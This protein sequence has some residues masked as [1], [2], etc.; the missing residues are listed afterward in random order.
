LLNLNFPMTLSEPSLHTDALDLM[1]LAGVPGLSLALV[2]NDEVNQVLALGVRNVQ[3]REPVNAETI[4]EAASLSK[5]VVAYA[6]LQLVDAGALSLDVPLA[7]Y[8]PSIVPDDAAAVL[9][10]ARHVL[11]H[12][13]GLPNL[14]SVKYPLRTFFSPG[15]RFSYSGQGFA[16]LQLAVESLLGEALE[17]TLRRL[18]F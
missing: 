5:P 11:S 9:I 2:Q 15:S 3:S 4:F 10:T 16:F 17:V 13:S 8:C 6:V 7:H 12:T 1:Q 18:V 14:G